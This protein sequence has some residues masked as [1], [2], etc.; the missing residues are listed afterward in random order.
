MDFRSALEKIHC[1][2]LILSG[3]EDPITPPHLSRE[4][5]TCIKDGIATLHI[6][7]GCGH[8]AFRDKP[9][10]VLGDVRRFVAGL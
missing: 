10:L 9:Q 5:M 6:Y 8:G 7:D 4:I 2:T 1:P 3:A